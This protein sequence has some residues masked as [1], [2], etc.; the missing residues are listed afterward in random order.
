MTQNIE[1]EI[2]PDY[3]NWYMRSRGLVIEKSQDSPQKLEPIDESKEALNIREKE[4]THELLIA[5][6][7]ELFEQIEEM[8]DVKKDSKLN[9]EKMKTEKKASKNKEKNTSMK[10]SNIVFS[11]LSWYSKKLESKLKD[12]PKK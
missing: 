2:L 12:N 8:K 6:T 7:S 11:D 9:N 4:Q 10:K 3:I 5:L 1:E